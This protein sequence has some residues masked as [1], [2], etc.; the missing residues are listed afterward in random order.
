VLQE[1]ARRIQG[2]A[3]GSPGAE[4][5]GQQ[6]GVGQSLR[7]PREQTLTRAL[8]AWP[9]ADANSLI[10]SA[11]LPL[12]WRF[13]DARNEARIANNCRNYWRNQSDW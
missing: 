7:A 5:H 2:I 9:L 12:N 3:T 4:D 6:L 8:S 11:I 1:L 10:H 13:A